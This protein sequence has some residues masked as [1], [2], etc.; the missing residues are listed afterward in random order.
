MPNSQDTMSDD[1]ESDVS[2]SDNEHLKVFTIDD[3]PDDSNGD[4]SG[5]ELLHDTKIYV[6]TAMN[7]IQHGLKSE[8]CCPDMRGEK[9]D[10]AFLTKHLLKYLGHLKS[11]VPSQLLNDSRDFHEIDNIVDP[12][13][14]SFDA[15]RGLLNMV[16]NI[17]LAIDA[18]CYCGVDLFSASKF[19]V[20]NGCCLTN[21]L[22]K[23]SCK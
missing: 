10:V 18:F 9:K 20:G 16:E 22:Q 2:Y 1:E 23:L 7:A 6:D 17:V 3:E 11:K 5:E 14:H 12:L 19:K 4:D 15:R 21:C 8:I 13:L